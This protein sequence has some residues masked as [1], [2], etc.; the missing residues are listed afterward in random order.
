MPDQSRPY[1]DC[2]PCPQC[3]AHAWMQNPLSKA[4]AAMFRLRDMVCCG[5]C[6][7]EQRREDVQYPVPMIVSEK[8]LTDYVIQDAEGRIIANGFQYPRDIHRRVYDDD[9]VSLHYVDD[10]TEVMPRYNIK[11]GRPV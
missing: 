5:E 3:G 9:T 2:Q 1:D 6:N 7:Q 8:I 10:G 4:R 11:T